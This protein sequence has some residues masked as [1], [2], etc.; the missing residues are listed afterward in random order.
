MPSLFVICLGNSCPYFFWIILILDVGIFV[1]TEDPTFLKFAPIV[2]YS[3]TMI[4]NNGIASIMEIPMA[5][6]YTG[7]RVICYSKVCDHDSL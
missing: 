7:T 1:S 6:H 3:G 2:P 5:D 4:C